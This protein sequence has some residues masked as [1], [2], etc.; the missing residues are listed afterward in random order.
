MRLKRV[1]LRVYEEE[2]GQEKK[3][4]TRKNFKA[5]GSIKIPNVKPDTSILVQGTFVWLNKDGVKETEEFMED[6]PLHT[7][8]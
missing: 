5:R 7:L 8:R 1:V 3:L 2:N 6:I 4:I